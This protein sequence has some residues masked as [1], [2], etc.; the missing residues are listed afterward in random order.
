MSFG[1]L[2]WLRSIARAT[3]EY[4]IVWTV[5]LVWDTISTLRV[6][7]EVIWKRQWT[8][9]KA[10]YLL[11]RYGTLVLEILSAAV[12]LTPMSQDA[13][14]RIYWIQPL[15][16]VFV[17][18][19]CQS[20]MAVRIFA[21]YERER[22]MGYLLGILVA[23]EAIG[24]IAAST[25]IVPL[26]LFPLI[27]DALELNGCLV[28]AKEGEAG[29]VVLILAVFP[30]TFDTI[31]LALAA[32]RSI[33][34]HRKYRVKIPLLRTVVRDG[35]LYY[36]AISATHVATTVLWFQ[37]D[38]TVKSF[39]VPSSIVIPSLM[40]SRL[41]LSLLMRSKNTPTVRPLS[42]LSMQ[43]QQG[44]PKISQIP[45]SPCDMTRQPPA[46]L[47]GE[48]PFRG[49]LRASRD[50]Q[51]ATTQRNPPAPIVLEATSS[52]KVQPPSAPRTPEPL[53]PSPTKSTFRPLLTTRPSLV[54]RKSEQTIDTIRSRWSLG[55][56]E[57]PIM[58][59]Q[60]TQ[61]VVVSIAAME[62]PL[63]SSGPP[64]R[65]S[66]SPSREPLRGGSPCPLPSPDTSH[67]TLP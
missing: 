45:V 33:S 35:L 44:Q 25:R 29:R 28:V 3:H 58:A 62:D 55:S 32:Y 37:N 10:V 12:I 24:C 52:S 7:Y 26:N 53:A 50:A 21:I 15:T 63:P 27:A 36:L 16:I 8:L 54:S 67:L 65:R 39:N 6:E 4:L 19:I 60:V 41:I 31:I 20:I 43:E 46:V 13:C 59:I 64:S 1:D 61:E 22:R 42:L 14:H 18:I 49:D 34:L 2:N 57:P 11:N 23:L 40:C 48:A 51:A 38:I 56:T 17:I 30:F 9:L 66:L 5:I 47:C